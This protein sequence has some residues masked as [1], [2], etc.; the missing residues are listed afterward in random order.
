MIHTYIE[1]HEFLNRQ[2]TIQWFLSHPTLKSTT[3]VMVFSKY[4]S[5]CWN[6]TW[7][8]GES[9][10]SET[11]IATAA[12]AS[13]RLNLRRSPFLLVSKRWEKKNGL[14]CYDEIWGVCHFEP[15]ETSAHRISEQ[16]I[17]G[18]LT[19]GYTMG[20]FLPDLS[21]PTLHA[22]RKGSRPTNGCWVLGQKNGYR[23]FS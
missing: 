23:R 11:N 9:S 15:F 4:R 2:K 19:L 5:C 6:P 17:L 3:L 16:N 10:E 8:G 1:Y 21:L 20:R 22:M 14:H 12:T 18:P 7:L 13:W